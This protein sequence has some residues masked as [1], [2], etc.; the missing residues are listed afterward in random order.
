MTKVNDKKSSKKRRRLLIMILFVSFLI[1]MFGFTTYAWFSSNKHATIDS[2]DINVATVTGIQV[3]VDAI[4]WDNIVTKEQIMN[5][6][7]T[8]RAAENQ[9]P[10]TLS[11]VSTSG[12]VTRGRLD[13]FYGLTSED[14]KDS[15]TLTTIKENEI[16]C[17]GDSECVDKHFIAFDIFLLVTNPASLVITPNSNVIPQPG[18]ED[19][20]C[21]NAAR[22][23]FVV[24]G[25]VGP[26]AS[27]AAQNL[28]GGNSSVIWEPNYDVHTPNGVLAARNIYGLTT[29]LSGASRLP[30][31][32]VNAE[33]KTP[34]AIDKT[35]ESPYFSTVNPQIATTKAFSYT[36]V[37]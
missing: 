15:Y 7:K 8:Y 13:M 2:I 24:E 33:F 6:Y 35:D 17:S 12:N 18:E 14:E 36:H 3:S 27:A 5:A 16:Q 22:I 20:G 32:G 11:N 37:R 21:Q 9:L 4:N 23:G 26:N 31:K 10:D 25:T 1:M 28:R 34:V 29:S 30:Y 19:K